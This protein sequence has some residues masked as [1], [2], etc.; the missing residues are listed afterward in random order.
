MIS[1]GEIRSVWPIRNQMAEPASGA[2]DP[3]P[4]GRIN[5]KRPTRSRMAESTASGQPEAGWPSQHQTIQSHVGRTPKSSGRLQLKANDRISIRRPIRSRMA[6]STSGGHRSRATSPTT[7]HG[8]TQAEVRRPRTNG[9]IQ[10][11]EADARQ[12]SSCR[13]PRQRLLKLVY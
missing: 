4:N 12:Q 8:R 5:S 11:A 2:A 7:G 6:E 13:C 3:K 10:T 9:R 1:D